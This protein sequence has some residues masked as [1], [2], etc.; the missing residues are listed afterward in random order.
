M[1]LN[2]DS[3][4]LPAS[5]TLPYEDGNFGVTP[6]FKHITPLNVAMTESEGKRVFD[7]PAEV[8]EIRFAGDRN[9]APIFPADAM[10]RKKN[11]Q[12]ITYAEMFS[13]QY[14]QFIM[15]ETQSAKGTP[16]ENLERYGITPA[17]LSVCRALKIYVIETLEQLQ[18]PGLKALGMNGNEL[19][20]MAAR[21]RA[22]RSADKAVDETAA[23]K[24]EIE[25]LRAMIPSETPKPEEV[26]R[27]VST[28]GESA[29]LDG[30]DADGLKKLIKQKTGA[31]PRGNPSH[32]T[33]VEMA[34]QAETA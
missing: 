30:M 28:G 21:W 12:V 29:S 18:G 27:I 1:A 34:R 8:V 4:G 33:L 16:L 6:Y 2:M 24:A 3:G 7:P 31:T 13:D 5:I 15:G 25:K 10:C 19:K 14:R 20:E 17:Q 22:D 26:D 32:K 23:L 11:G 9:Y